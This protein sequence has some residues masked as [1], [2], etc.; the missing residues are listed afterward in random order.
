MD[1]KVCLRP[2]SEIE[3]TENGDIYTC[4][5]SYLKNYPIGNLFEVSSFDEIWY[6][7][8]AE[9]LRK[10]IIEG[11]YDFCNKEICNIKSEAEN[12]TV[13]ATPDYPTLVRFAYDKQCNLKCCICRDK[14]INSDNNV[15]SKFDSIIDSML[16]PL[17]K[18]AQI[19][20]I[21]SAGEITASQ[22]SQNLLKKAA[23][24]YPNLKFEILT[25]AFLFNEEFC[26]R[27]GII[28]KIDRVIVSMHGIN[29][30]TYERI[31]RGAK[32]EIVKKNL[33]WLFS[34]RKQHKINEV[35]I[36]FVVSSMNYKEIP[37]FVSYCLENQAVPIIWEYRPFN[38]VE[39]AKKYSE[40]A[41]WEKQNPNYNDFIKVISYVEENYKNSCRMPELFKNLEPISKFQE[42]MNKIKFLLKL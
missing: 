32:F 17:L 27:L 31:M 21:T 24:L 8:K 15:I 38:N 41:V 2:F 7:Q 19:M 16:L 20:S 18:N 33:D 1:K 35:S 5:P 10:N 26:T 36:V 12:T 25:N 4:C 28:N 3:I 6:S 9:D 14:L 39:M 37:N 34:L 30:S 22:H 23:E 13:S 40:H 11:K 29:K 42:Y